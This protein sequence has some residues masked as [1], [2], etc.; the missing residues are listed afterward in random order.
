MGLTPRLTSCR[1][2]LRFTRPQTADLLTPAR[3]Y[4]LMIVRFLKVRGLRTPL[5]VALLGLALVGTGCANNKKQSATTAPGSYQPAPRK[6]VAEPSARQDV[7]VEQSVRYDV[8][9]EEYPDAIGYE[10]LS[11]G[12]QVVVV[13]YVHTY[14]EEIETFPQVTWAGRTYYN[15]HG[16]FVYWYDG[17]GW[18]YY[19]GPPAPLVVYWNGYYPWA[20]YAWGVGYYGPGWYWGGVGMYGYHAYGLSVV[21]YNHHHHHYHANNTRPGRDPRPTQ[22]TRVPPSGGGTAGP[23]HKGEPVPGGPRKPGRPD[24]KVDPSMRTSPGSSPTRT[25]PGRFASSDTPTRRN[26]ESNPSGRVRTNPSPPTRTNGY[27]TAGGNR[28]TIID[29]R[30]T[31]T[32]PAVRR[33]NPTTLGSVPSANGPRRTNPSTPAFKAPRSNPTPARTNGKATTSP[34]RTPASTPS[35]GSS[36]N[37]NPKRSQPA[38]TSNPSRSS[39]PARSN[40]SRSSTPSRTSSPSR[41]SAPRRSSPSRSSAP[42]RSA[43][44]RSSAPRRSAPSRSA[45]KRSS[46]KRR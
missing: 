39:S 19:L 7:Y 15:V 21:H 9:P 29:P 28:V 27:T 17:W 3:P 40:P 20:P 38:R 31:R 13:E 42:K 6:I 11:N 4:T 25:S 45:P 10:E 34:R 23:V 33:T 44:S 2:G 5:G 35:W 24:S 43:P 26:P 12:E 1:G 32:S 36:Y 14:P 37:N 41:S 22:T 18:C 8:A 16:D 46:P 30:A